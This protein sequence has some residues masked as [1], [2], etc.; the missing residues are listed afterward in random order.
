MMAHGP[1]DVVHVAE[2][3]EN[4]GRVVLRL[5]TA[6]PDRFAVLAALRLARAYQAELESIFIEDQQL[7]DLCAHADASEISLCGR[8]RRT[9]SPVTLMRQ[10]AYAARQAER[11]VAAMAQRAEITYRARTMRDEPMHALNRACAES[12]PWNVVVLADPVRARDRH[13]VQRLLEEM[14]GATALML[15]GAA[16]RRIDGPVMIVLES[17]DRLPLMLRVAERVAA[18]ASAPIV[19]AL[20]AGSET[21]SGTMEEHVRLLLAERTDVHLTS[22]ARARGHTGALVEAVRRQQPGF[23]IGQAG[24]VLLPRDSGWNDVARA[25]ECPLF[26]MR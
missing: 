22:L 11:Q 14:V 18:E 5:G 7:I 2:A 19:V 9:L 21:F 26:V 3:G 6:A 13:A 8:D 20:A 16:V 25:L 12:G 1:V 23:L 10:F 24:G 17:I 4:R 15:V